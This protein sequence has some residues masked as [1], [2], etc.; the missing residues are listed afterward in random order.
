MM[1]LY[2]GLLDAKFKYMCTANMLQ[3]L[4]GGPFPHL[5]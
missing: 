2:S 4:G 1:I 5:S 3:I